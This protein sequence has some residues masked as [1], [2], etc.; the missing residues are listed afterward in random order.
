MLE[1]AAVTPA[2]DPRA[3]RLQDPIAA[4]KEHVLPAQ[5]RT[6]DTERRLAP[7]EQA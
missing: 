7:E 2:Q 1:Q 3:D 4:G 5:G 6:L